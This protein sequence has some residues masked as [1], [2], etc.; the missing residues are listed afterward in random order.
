LKQ[1]CVWWSRLARAGGDELFRGAGSA[2]GMVCEMI[3]AAQSDRPCGCGG[4]AR[5]DREGRM[6]RIKGFVESVDLA[7][8]APVARWTGSPA[9]GTLPRSSETRVQA[10]ARGELA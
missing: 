2:L 4:Q 9:E 6:E 5:A 3:D 1:G 10:I 8:E 7:V